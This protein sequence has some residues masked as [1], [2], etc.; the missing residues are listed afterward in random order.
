[1]TRLLDAKALREL[2]G[3]SDTH[4]DRMVKAGELPKPI[5]FRDGG[6]N[7]WTEAELDALIAEKLAERDAEKALS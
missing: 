3:Y 6:K 2:F 4:I 5:K 7:Y 1:M